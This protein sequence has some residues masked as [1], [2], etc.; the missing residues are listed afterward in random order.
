MSQLNSIS[1]EF[2]D[3]AM[4]V[5]E[6]T[7]LAADWACERSEEGMI[8]CA[9]MTKWGEFG[10]MFAWRDEP[11]SLNFSLTLDLRAPNAKQSAISELLRKINERLW[12]GHFDYWN[13]EGV[14]VFRHTIPMFDRIAPDP[15]EIAAVL[16]AALEAADQFLPAFNFVVW[17][18]KSAEEAVAAVVF[19]THGEA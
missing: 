16:T 12:L 9:S 2:T 19:E 5:V 4:D 10:G 18:G 7:L 15:G 13:D 14:A 6:Q 11:A 8:H 1:A 17:A 3:R